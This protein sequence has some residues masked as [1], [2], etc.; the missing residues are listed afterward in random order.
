ML[1][2]KRGD[3]AG[4]LDTRPTPDPTGA[5]SDTTTVHITSQ[6]DFSLLL[7][8]RQDE[9][10]SDAESDGVSFCS[11]ESTDP[12]CANRQQV[13]DGFITA[14]AYAADPDGAWVQV[15]GCIDPSKSTLDPSDAGGQMDVRFPNGAQCTFGGFGASFIELV[16]PALNR[17]CIRCCRDQ[18]DQT[19]CNSHRDRL[20]CETAIPGTYD[21]PEVG[22]SCS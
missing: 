15:T 10:V 21:F 14:A 1:R 4:E 16:E 18:N 3:D 13:Q 17:F 9:L 22:I 19:N 2:F 11:T 12:G 6:A 7:P 5:P 20:G 8:G